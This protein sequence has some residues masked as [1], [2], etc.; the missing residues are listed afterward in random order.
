ME[1]NQASLT[2]LALRGYERTARM[3]NYQDI[4]LA[5]TT[6]PCVGCSV[7][8]PREQIMCIQIERFGRYVLSSPISVIM[9]T[10]YPGM[11]ARTPDIPVFG[12]GD[13]WAEALGNL[14]AE[15]A[16]LYEDLLEDDQFTDEWLAIKAYLKQKV[17]VA[18][19]ER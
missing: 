11:I 16:S 4:L 13:D 5:G 17:S 14:Q 7:L 12:H 3:V 9:E 8:R 19:E 2:D 18:S 15:L 6:S 1:K 10:D